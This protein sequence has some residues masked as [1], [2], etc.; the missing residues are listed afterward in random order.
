MHKKPSQLLDW[1]DR[2]VVISLKR[3]PER[4]AA[5]RAELGKQHWPF[6]EPQVF[7]AIDGGSGKV[8]T[9]LGWNA[10]GGA[11]GCMQSHRHVLEQALIDDVQSLLV[12]EDDACLRPDFP[13]SVKRFLAN[14][15]N[16]WDQL[17]L[18]GQHIGDRPKHVADGLVKC[19]NCQRTHAYA[20]RG[21]FIRR[22]Y[23]K[24][25]SSSG[26]CDHVMGPMQAEFN[27]YAP[28]PF[29]IG[30]DMSKSDISGSLNP[31]KFW[32]P[33]AGNEPVV[34]LRAP[35]EVVAELRRRG[36]HTGYNRDPGTDYD[37][38][39][40]EI[41]GAASVAPSSHD[42]VKRLREW[43]DMILWEVASTEGLVCTIW[44]PAV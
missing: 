21:E 19:L 15:P 36:F 18:G 4:L 39:L 11:W 34:L 44:H 40:F 41:F 37:R 30:Q 27:V 28:D 23:Q 35:R 5:F 43:I 42:R 26:H 25:V 8:P 29:L 20:V 33:P 38:G 13:E 31:R 24:W 6:R 9:P 3:R 10:G 2:V 14:V 1:F 16:D 22:L 32:T 7:A 12:L 17:M